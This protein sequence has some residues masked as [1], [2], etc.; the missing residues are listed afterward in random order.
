MLN[1]NPTILARQFVPRPPRT[2]QT[3]IREYVASTTA[4]IDALVTKVEAAVERLQ[5]YRTALISAAVTGK[6]RI[7]IR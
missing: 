2:E 4:R 7:P 5:E 6:V 3:E 1:I